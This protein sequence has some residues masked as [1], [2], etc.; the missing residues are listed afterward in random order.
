M[1]EVN[2]ALGLQQGPNAGEAFTNA[3]RQGQQARQQNM[4][5]SAMAALVQDPNNQR[6]LEALAQ[7]DPQA[8]MQFQERQRQQALSGLERHR[9]NI[10][11]GAQIIRQLQPKDQA[12]WDQARTMASQLGIDVSEVPPQFDPQYV[13]G[14]VGIA[15]ALAPRSGAQDPGIIREFEIA[16]QRGLVQPGTSYQQYLQMRNPGMLAP[17]T[18]PENAVV[19]G[20]ANL[21]TVASPDDAMRLPPGSQFRMP[22]GRI[23]TVPNRG[24]QT[25]APSGPFQP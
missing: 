20:G 25:V 1:G 7:V 16:T 5:K 24:G 18:I 15:D 3:F 22:D 8:A 14:L 13:Q 2:W 23:G 10:V 9:E 11:K 17:V 12:G 6:A 21:P 4:A 19:E